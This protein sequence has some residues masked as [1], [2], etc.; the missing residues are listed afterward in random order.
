MVFGYLER[1]VRFTHSR[2]TTGL[3]FLFLYNLLSG[4]ISTSG[5]GDT[6]IGCHTSICMH[7][8]LHFKAAK[9][10]AVVSA[11]ALHVFI[12]EIK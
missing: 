6:K 1:L 12:H 9:R 5:G 11:A 2:L 7:F 4:H 10:W 8:S 3:P